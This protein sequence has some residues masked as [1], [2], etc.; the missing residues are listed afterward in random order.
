MPDNYAKNDS[1]R[2]NNVDLVT[3][4]RSK[5]DFEKNDGHHYVE[6]KVVGEYRLEGSPSFAAEVHTDHSSFTLSS[7]EPVI[8]GGAGIHVSPFTYVLFGTVACF[9]TTVAMKCAEKQI[10]LEKLRVSGTVHY[11]IGPMLSSADWPLVNELI[12]EVESDKDIAQIVSD[13]KCPSLFT[14]AHEIKTKIVQT[15]TE[16]DPGGSSSSS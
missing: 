5:A 16:I 11:D 6:K 1:S 7:D 12:L 13:A 8:L 4:E 9:A 3:V 10:Q 14:W 2:L 15:L